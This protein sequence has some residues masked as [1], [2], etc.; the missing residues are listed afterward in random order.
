LNSL[1]HSRLKT[2]DQSRMSSK[3]KPKRQKSASASIGSKKR[4]SSAAAAAD[5]DKHQTQTHQSKKPLN[6]NGKNHNNRNGS[7]ATANANDS[8]NGNGHDNDTL[9]Q[10]LQL[11][12]P[13]LQFFTRATGQRSVPLTTLLGVGA[14]KSSSTSSSANTNAVNTNTNV[15]QKSA[16]PATTATAVQK[17]ELPLSPPLSHIP[18]LADRGVLHVDIRIE[19]QTSTLDG[20]GRRD[21]DNDNG[22]DDNMCNPNGLLVLRQLMS[23]EPCRVFVGFPLPP[24]ASD[25]GDTS[26][27]NGDNQKQK[28]KASLQASGLHPSTKTAAK[29]RLAALKRSLKQD[30]YYH[31]ACTNAAQA[32]LSLSRNNTTGTG[33]DGDKKASGTATD[34]ALS[35][36]VNPDEIP[37]S[38]YTISGA[39]TEK[40]EVTI[41]ALKELTSLL[42]DASVDVDVPATSKDEKE[43]H[44]IDPSSSTSW[45]LPGQAKHAGSGEARVLRTKQL[46]PQVARLIP[47]SLANALGLSLDNGDGE[48][49]GSQGGDNHDH[50]HI[51]NETPK[52]KNR[53]RQLFCHQA[54]AV[55][56]A[57]HGRHTIVCTSTG[58]GKSLCFLLPVLAAAMGSPLP[59]QTGKEHDPHHSDDQNAS[60]LMF[61]TKALAQDQLSKIHALLEEYPL[62]RPYIR[63]ATLDGDTPHSERQSIAQECNVILTNPDT[64][65]AAILPNWKYAFQ[66]LLARIK[67]VVIDE[68]HMYQGTFGAHVSLILTRLVRI[69]RIAAGRSNQI[70]PSAPPQMSSNCQRQQWTRPIFMACSATMPFPEEHFRLLCPIPTTAQVTVIS[71]ED[72]GSPWYVRLHCRQGPYSTVKDVSWTVGQ[73]MYIKCHRKS[74]VSSCSLHGLRGFLLLTT[75]LLTYC[76][77]F[78]AFLLILFHYLPLCLHRRRIA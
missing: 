54:N 19:L 11:L 61:P 41:E 52:R 48:G 63:A 68:A 27:H 1:H 71:R 16:A 44:K 39:N 66:P 36:G 46:S 67:F 22:N 21:D 29:R 78:A 30:P 53:K 70:K 25:D 2:Q 51:H 12:E 62:L 10:A 23:T 60:I 7:G 75:Q 5:G 38:N 76:I 69:C 13:F 42:A 32:L 40:D 49:P 31:N 24:D 4:A 17:E 8:D 47:K 59:I 58:S 64:L 77:L 6:K 45:I 20:G 73:R 57:C 33:D 43:K 55:D 3:P 35:A 26:T 37:P 18:E 56:A 14:L 74:T 28:K 34:T 15:Q 50:D 9:I 65:H 72:D